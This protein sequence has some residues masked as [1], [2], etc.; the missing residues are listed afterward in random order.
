VGFLGSTFITCNH[1]YDLDELDNNEMIEVLIVPLIQLVTSLQ[2]KMKIVVSDYNVHKNTILDIKLLKK[3]EKDLKCCRSI[4]ST[5][6]KSCI[7]SIDNMLLICPIWIRDHS[8]EYWSL[9]ITTMQ[10]PLLC[11]SGYKALSNTATNINTNTI[12]NTVIINKMLSYLSSALSN[13]SKYSVN[14][15]SD[16]LTAMHDLCQKNCI[17]MLY[18]DHLVLDML[19]AWNSLPRYLYIYIYIYIILT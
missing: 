5:I 4:C 11:A 18:H 19:H 7:T 3:L 9:C 14:T 1:V 16:I 6:R 12:N 13:T 15:A 8:N 17:E 10:T 2:N